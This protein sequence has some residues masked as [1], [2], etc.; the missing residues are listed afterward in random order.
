[1]EGHGGARLPPKAA[2]NPASVFSRLL[3]QSS[4]WPSMVNSS[5]ETWMREAL[6][7]AKTGAEAGEV[8]VGAVIVRDNEILGRGWNRPIGAHDPTAHAEILALRDAAAHAGNYRLPGSTLY[9]TLEPCVMCVGAFMHARVDRVVYGTAE[10]KAGAMESTQRAHEHA[11]LNHRV[12]VVSGV[13]AAEC[14]Q[15]LQEFFRTRRA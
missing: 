9:V 13:L 14:R 5:L 12:T 1:M 3:S 6:A 11:A 7:L 10:P 2:P 8:P 15:V 4:S